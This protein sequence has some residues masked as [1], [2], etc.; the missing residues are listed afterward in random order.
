MATKYANIKS[1]TFNDGHLGPEHGG[2]A[3]I[4][5]DMLATATT[6]GTDTVQLGGG[7]Y[8]EGVATTSTL[9]ALLKARRQDGKTV[10]IFDAMPGRFTGSQAAATNGPEIFLQTVAASGGNVTAVLKTAYTAG[11]DVST[12]VAAWDR[13]CGITVHYK[14]V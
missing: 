11:S 13:A 8:D 2:V 14:A 6:G 7:G 12:T 1:V 3:F 5:F 9:A 4:S 10:T